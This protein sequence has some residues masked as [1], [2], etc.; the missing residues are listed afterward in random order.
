MWFFLLAL[1]SHKGSTEESK[2]Q[3]IT[4]Y[5]QEEMNAHS[6]AATGA[7]GAS[8]QFNVSAIQRKHSERCLSSC[9]ANEKKSNNNNNN[10]RAELQNASTPTHMERCCLCVKIK[11]KTMVHNPPNVPTT[12]TLGAAATR[13]KLF[14]HYVHRYGGPCGI[15]QQRSW[16]QCY[17]KA[18]KKQLYVAPS[19]SPSSSLS[20]DADRVTFCSGQAESST[21]SADTRDTL[22]W[23]HYLTTVQFGPY[24]IL[25]VFPLCCPP[26]FAAKRSFNR[27]STLFF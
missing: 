17:C 21:V 10:S 6:T 27:V 8:S 15:K 25:A 26:F 7:G 24:R 12:K 13:R 11:Q 1:L 3:S 2:S 23:S 16:L 5:C 9:A 19:A 20:L 22:A 14:L 18:K 4:P